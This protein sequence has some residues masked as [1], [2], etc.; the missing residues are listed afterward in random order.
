[1][2]G[3]GYKVKLGYKELRT[4]EITTMRSAWAQEELPESIQSNDFFLEK[5]RASPSF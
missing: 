3:L 2:A 4:S 1:M 5:N